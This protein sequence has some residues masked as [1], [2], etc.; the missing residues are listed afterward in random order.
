MAPGHTHDGLFAVVE[1]PGLFIAGDY[2]SDVEFPYIYDSSAAYEATLG[3][4]GQI[5]A[6]HPVPLLIP[7]HGEAAES[8]LEIERR[9][10]A[11]LDYIRSL[12]AAVAAGDQA[13]VEQLIAGCAFPRNMR[14]FHRSNQELMEQ[15]LSGAGETAGIAEG[16]NAVDQGT[17]T[18]ESLR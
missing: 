2:L 6:Q 13:A 7:G 4:A 15:E 10:D 3:K 8:L 5:I 18:G 16:S 14:K 11:G 1:S 12:R 17:I 9:R